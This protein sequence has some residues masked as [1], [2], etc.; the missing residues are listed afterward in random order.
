MSISAEKAQELAGTI[1]IEE[2]RSHLRSI[3]ANEIIDNNIDLVPGDLRDDQDLDE[4]GDF[5]E[6]AALE[7]HVNWNH[8]DLEGVGQ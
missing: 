8:L 1:L 7:M 3:D 2:V 4:I 5:I 6:I